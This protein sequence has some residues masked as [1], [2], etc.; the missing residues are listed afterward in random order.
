[1]WCEMHE[2][3]ESDDEAHRARAVRQR[4]R[5]PGET[6][7]DERLEFAHLGRFG[8]RQNSSTTQL[9]VWF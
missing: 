4:V 9:S 5:V 2:K 8:E 3:H 7:Q 6:R 1:M